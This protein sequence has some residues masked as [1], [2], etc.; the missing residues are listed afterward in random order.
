[1]VF[2]L[3]PTDV[4]SLFE[5]NETHA[6]KAER[7]LSTVAFDS[8]Y[9]ILSLLLSVGI[10]MDVWSHVVYG[11]DQTL[12]NEYHLLFYGAMAAIGLLLSGLAV[13]NLRSGY[14]LSIALPQGY[15]LGLFAT[16]LF[17]IAGGIDLTSH[18][19][20]GF[21]SDMEAL[22]SPPHL[23]LMA[24]WFLILFAPVRAA[25]ARQLATGNSEG[26]ARSLPRLITYG[27]MI[28][29]IHVPFLEFYI[30]GGNT[31]MLQQNR[32]DDEFMGLVMGITGMLLQ[33]TVIA[34]FMLWLAR[35]FKMPLGGFTI[36]LALYGLFL[37]MLEGWQ[38]PWL[39]LGS[40]GLL[41][42]IAYIALKPDA[43]RRGRF[44]LFAVL[45]PLFMWS[46]FY[47]TLIYVFGGTDQF[48]YSGYNFF[49]SIGMTVALSALVGYLL[50]MPAPRSVAQPVTA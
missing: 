45:L 10:M 9:V 18:A 19:L 29:C 31:W 43:L 7:P 48:Y 13:A 27:C 38:L 36:V 26:L 33:T 41:L 14:P 2:P 1:M 15:G 44:M 4:K 6:A 23:M 22:T 49:G 5:L 50:S 34:G 32:P 28:F 30:I 21:E 12:F 47:G 46:T 20:F 8:L 25:R 3:T 11:P 24:A 40:F 42:D 16:I 37:T 17:A 39:M 35:E